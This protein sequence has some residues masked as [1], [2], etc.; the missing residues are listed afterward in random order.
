MRRLI[1]LLIALSFFLPLVAVAAPVDPDAG[2]LGGNQPAL[3]RHHTGTYFRFYGS[4]SVYFPDFYVSNGVT[5]FWQQT[6]PN[7]PCYHRFYYAGTST[8]IWS[9]WLDANGPGSNTGGVRNLSGATYKLSH[10]A[11]CQYTNQN[12]G[13]YYWHG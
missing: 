8:V 7:S 10:T 5:H 12:I 13:V 3:E 6:A 11:Y 1:V 4:S 9:G 2:G